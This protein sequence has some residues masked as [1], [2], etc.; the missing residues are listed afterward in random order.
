MMTYCLTTR[1]TLAIVY[2]NRIEHLLV[3]LVVM[4]LEVQSVR[5]KK[6]KKKTTK[7]SY[8]K[9]VSCQKDVYESKKIEIENT[10][11]V[12]RCIDK[13]TIGSLLDSVT[14]SDMSIFITSDTVPEQTASP[15]NL[16]ISSSSSQKVECVS[17]TSDVTT[18][19]TSQN[20]NEGKMYSN[21]IGE[22][23]SNFDQDY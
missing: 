23:P 1:N 9:H 15:S 8:Q 5:Q 20:Q 22:W 2:F 4:V 7:L 19:S 10:E 17:Q 14:I 12:S 18:S 21:D 11:V 3:W 16:A 6:K 13:S